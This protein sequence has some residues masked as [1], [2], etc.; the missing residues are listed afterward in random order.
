MQETSKQTLK[1]NLTFQILIAM[2]LGG[3]LGIFIHN[4]DDEIRTKIKK[5]WCEE[6][7]VQNNPLL[8]ISKNV[9]FH[10]F[11]EI[12]VE[13]EDSIMPAFAP[14]PDDFILIARKPTRVKEEKTDF[15]KT[16]Y[17]KVAKQKL[18]RLYLNTLLEMV[19]IL[20]EI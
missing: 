1:N 3:I 9:I 11:N 7:N 16:K 12:N 15:K 19:L 17:I 6:A 18:E 5:A 2:V 20:L 8:E 4:S 14:T 10:E 13:I